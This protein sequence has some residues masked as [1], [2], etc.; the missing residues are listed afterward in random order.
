MK[1]DS[2]SHLRRP[3]L[4]IQAPCGGRTAVVLALLAILA[5]G[6][7]EPIGPGTDSSP[8]TIHELPRPLSGPEVAAISANNEFGFD[9]MREV[10][11][12][13][14]SADVFLSPLSASMALAMTMNGAA[15]GTFDAIRGS[16]RFGAVSEPEINSAYRGLLDLLTGL[17]GDVDLA[18]GNAIWYRDD[19]TART[20]FRARVET[21]F[22]ARVQGLDFGAPGAAG[23]IN[24]WASES[25]R[26]RIEKMV[27]PPVP[28]NVLAY[29]MNAVYFKAGW[30]QPFDPDLTSDAL[31]H[32][33]DGSSKPVQLM[34]RDDTLRYG[35]GADYTAVDLPY[36]GQAFSMTIL[37][38]DF[39][40]DLSEIVERMDPEEW[41][42]LTADL[43][44]TRVQLFLP[45]FELE[46]EGS[47]NDAL[48]AMGMGI[49]FEPGSADLSRLFESGQG[50]I[51]QVKQKSFVRVDEEGTEAAA[52]TSVVI[53]DSTP[54]QLRA[55][56]PFLFVIRERLSGTV[57][58]LGA[59]REAPRD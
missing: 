40:T 7:S 24:D 15:G 33:S 37:L 11:S 26:G 53:I 28:G 14:P 45:R 57:L 48:A 4:P 55:D 32:L 30:T 21:S 44:T 17:D 47:F 46:W 56:R 20:D 29:L 12:A 3:S 36:A 42:A 13:D 35:V 50:W 16:L 5:S 9:L 27:E 54:P 10:A 2:F 25:T 43:E 59:I 22:G 38:P 31:F 6:C 52:V 1:P 41:G 49:A 58:F 18:I 51:D 34:M 19:L 23:I 39:G 8:S